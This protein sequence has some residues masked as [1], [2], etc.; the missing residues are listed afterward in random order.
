MAGAALNQQMFLFP[1]N[2]VNI[3]FKRKNTVIPQFW[4]EI[5]TFSLTEIGVNPTFNEA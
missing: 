1:T 3:K 4:I 5:F 2:L